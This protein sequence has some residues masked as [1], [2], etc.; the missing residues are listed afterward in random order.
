MSGTVSCVYSASQ[1]CVSRI[2]HLQVEGTRIGAIGIDEDGI[3]ACCRQA[4]GGAR[5]KLAALDVLPRDRFG[6]GLPGLQH[7]GPYADAAGLPA[8]GQRRERR[9]GGDA[10]V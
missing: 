6:P 9:T 5:L 2:G 10:M 1:P 4:L 8:R 7:A 3:C